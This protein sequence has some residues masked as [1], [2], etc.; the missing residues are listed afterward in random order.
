MRKT[1]GHIAS[2]LLI[3]EFSMSAISMIAVMKVAVDRFDTLT[4]STPG[5]GVIVLIGVLDLLGVIGAVAGFRRPAAAVAA[6]V[7]FALLS[8]GILYRQLSHGAH[9]SE[10]ISY[11]L[12]LAA[13]LVM[14]AAR[15]AALRGRGGAARSTMAAAGAAPSAA[16]S[17]GGQRRVSASRRG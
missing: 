2:G 11:S 5:H 3:L 15:A 1:I 6:G 12:F 14:I 16:R 7:W 4:R 9:G 13:A 17:V 10:L 8:G